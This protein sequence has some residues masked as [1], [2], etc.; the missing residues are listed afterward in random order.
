VNRLIDRMVDVFQNIS[1]RT[2]VRAAAY[3]FLVCVVAW[4]V[5]A[6]TVFRGEQ[7]GILGLS[8]GA[9]ILESLVLIVTT[10]IR[11]ETD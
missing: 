2:R 1:P 5:T 7:Q 6:L 4:P 8:W 11:E 10:D 3:M 9:V